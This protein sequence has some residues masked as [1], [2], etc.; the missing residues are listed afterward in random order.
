[1]NGLSEEDKGAL[2]EELEEETQPIFDLLK[3]IELSLSEIKRLNAVS[4]FWVQS[5][6]AGIKNEK[7]TF[8]WCL[9]SL[10]I[11]AKK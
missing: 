10:Y 7:I 8:R 3:K 2:L 4:V 11:D 1:V 5:Y 9:G 6:T